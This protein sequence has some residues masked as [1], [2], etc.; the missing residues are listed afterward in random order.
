MSESLKYLSLFFL[1][2]LIILFCMVH[3]ISLKE[4]MRTDIR[5]DIDPMTFMLASYPEFSY[6]HHCICFAFKLSMH[7]SQGL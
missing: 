4:V 7:H 5:P 1:F 3:R 2:F 6:T